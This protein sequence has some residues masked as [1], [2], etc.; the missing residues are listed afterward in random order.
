M[1]FVTGLNVP[2]ELR[3]PVYVEHNNQVE[4]AAKS[5]TSRYISALAIRTSSANELVSQLQQ[6]LTLFPDGNISSRL[7]LS[8]SKFRMC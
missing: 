8:A 6:N 5:K 2:V 4:A 3:E 1:V 7:G